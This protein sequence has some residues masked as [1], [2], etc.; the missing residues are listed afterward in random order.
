MRYLVKKVNVFKEVKQMEDN[1][2]NKGNKK[3]VIIAVIVIVVGL[4]IFFVMGAIKKSHE[5]PPRPG[6]GPGGSIVYELEDAQVE[7]F[8]IG[9]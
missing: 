5:R 3:Y 7:D 6:E 1:N 8:F 4:I 2:N 9:A